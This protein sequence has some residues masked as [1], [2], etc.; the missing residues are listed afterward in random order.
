MVGLAEV[1]CSG[2]SCLKPY[3]ILLLLFTQ[4]LGLGEDGAVFERLRVT[5]ERVNNFFSVSVLLFQELNVCMLHLL[6]SVI[7]TEMPIVFHLFIC[8]WDGGRCSSWPISIVCGGS[9]TSSS[10]IIFWRVHQLIQ[11]REK[12]TSDLALWLLNFLENAISA[13]DDTEDGLP[14]LANDHAEIYRALVCILNLLLFS[15]DYSVVPR[16]VHHHEEV[17]FLNHISLFA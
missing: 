14:W 2:P 7:V 4:V 17:T 8:S 13:I 6:C 5:Y 16:V 12:V 3:V 11:P 1:E 10:I 15:L 9:C